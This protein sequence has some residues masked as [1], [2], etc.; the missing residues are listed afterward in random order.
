[1]S[2]LTEE[3]RLALIKAARGGLCGVCRW[4]KLVRSSRASLFA[5]CSHPELPRYPGQ[6]V[7]SCAL[8]EEVAGEGVAEEP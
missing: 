5:L 4:A 6:P 3:D 8:F 7:L 2:K 1:L